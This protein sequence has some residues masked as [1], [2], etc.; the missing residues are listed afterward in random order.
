MIKL[1]PVLIR[2]LIAL[3]NGARVTMTPGGVPIGAMP[4]GIASHHILWRLRTLGLVAIKVRPSVNRWE[5]TRA[6]KQL[7]RARGR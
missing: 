6:G 5:I 1:S 2:A 4:D 7:L 3:E